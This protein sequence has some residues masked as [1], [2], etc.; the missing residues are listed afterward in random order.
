MKE[1]F[2]MTTLR[3]GLTAGNG[4]VLATPF[5]RIDGTA[6]GDDAQPSHTIA[7]VIL[8]GETASTFD[9]AWELERSRGLPAWSAVMAATQTRGRGQLRREWISPRG[10]LY[11]SFFLPEDMAKLGDMASLATGYCIHA[12][13]RAMGIETLLKWPNDLLLSSGGMEGK[14]GGLL[15]EE[16]G[17]R[18]LAGLGLN[19]ASAPG[20]A[21]MRQDRAVPAAA[22]HG[23]GIKPLP[24]WLDMQPRLQDVYEREIA[25]ASLEAL[26]AAIE[27]GLAWKGRRVYA[28]DAGITGVLS[29]VAPDGALLLLTDAG[30]AAVSSG[31]INP[32]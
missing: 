17:G 29:G 7:P 19:L 23:A 25:G 22:L 30:I 8:A 32:A 1:H 16:R 31:S 14:F 13:L 10:N 11:V 9:L 3:A 12:A 2:F 18:I 15:L 26:K 5:S 21:A 28:E 27:T 6:L 24:L 4:D 20:N